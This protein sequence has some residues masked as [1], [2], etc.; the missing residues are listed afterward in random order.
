MTN[1]PTAVLSEVLH[2]RV[3]GRV[4]QAAVFTTFSFEPGFFEQ[5]IVPT[6]FEQSFSQAPRVRLVQLEETLRDVG[7]LAIYFDRRGLVAGSDSA[8]LD[9]QRVAVTHARGLFHPKLVLV[10]AKDATGSDDDSVAAPMRLIVGVLS[11]NLT[12]AG[13]WENVECA[14]FEDIVAG[15]RSSIRR[16]LMDLLSG[17][18]RAD[19]TGAE[20]PALELI[21]RFLRYEVTDNPQRTTNRALNPRVWV[22]QA[23]FH[24]FLR[25]TLAL[26]AGVYNLEVVS[27]YFDA[28]GDGQAVAALIEQLEPKATRIYEPRADD[29]STECDPDVYR[30]IASLPDLSWSAFTGAVRQRGKS[31]EEKHLL[32]RVHAKVYR[33]WSKAEGREFLAMG[34]ANMTTPGHSGATRRNFE[35]TAVFEVSQPKKLDWWL[36]PVD[37]GAVAFREAG[38][39]G[40]GSGETPPPLSIRFDWTTKEASYFC[41]DERPEPFALWSA[42]ELLAEV[43]APRASQWLCLS[44]SCAERLSETLRSTSSLDVRVG[45]EPRG[46]I[47]VTEVGMAHKPSIMFSMT[48]EEILRYWSLLSMEQREAFLE[49][50]LNQELVARGLAPPRDEADARVQV[51]MFDRFAGVFHAFEHLEGHVRRALAEGRTRE[52]VY[53]LFGQKYDSLPGLLS[54]AVAPRNA[55]GEA[56]EADVKRDPLMDYVTVL[57]AESLVCRLAR[58]PAAAHLF[59]QHRAAHKELKERFALGRSLARELDLGPDADVFVRWFETWFMRPASKVGAP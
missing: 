57:S 25:D 35:A 46:T 59:E 21:R 22:S 16:D 31:G 54:K 47:L 44:G 12:R 33:L 39:S 50:K 19:A 45:G 8:A 34:S 7:P 5:E 1:A 32:R 17:L 26:P 43:K 13:W 23:P 10:L 41:E 56:A 3:A 15:S 29:G 37:T 40:E 58:E 11:A 4:V 2:R 14:W 9:I 6:L 49:G 27:P 30:G 38:E 36:T 53:R 55:A 24:E 18:R 42:G 52:V 51:S 20:Q 28:H 48:M